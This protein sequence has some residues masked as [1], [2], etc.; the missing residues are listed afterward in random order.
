MRTQPK[1]KT[2]KARKQPTP[3]SQNWDIW[4]HKG[5]DLVV[6]YYHNQFD[7]GYWERTHTPPAGYDEGP[8]DYI[9][10]YSLDKSKIRGI[11]RLKDVPQRLVDDI[12][13]RAL[14]FIMDKCLLPELDEGMIELYQ[15][16][17]DNTSFLGVTRFTVVFGIN[18][19]IVPYY[20]R[21]E[22]KERTFYI[23]RDITDME[24]REWK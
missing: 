17:E 10:T 23:T 6:P 15:V 11:D 20:H 9:R 21:P 24:L 22:L 14:R 4:G 5:S 16:N 2:T 19:F 8:T 3:P 7:K 18:T 12:L 13:N 1:R